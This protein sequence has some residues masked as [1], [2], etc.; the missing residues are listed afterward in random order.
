MIK[1]FS[2][3]LLAIIKVS[4]RSVIMVTINNSNNNNV[5]ETSLNDIAGSSKDVQKQSGVSPRRGNKEPT[6][7]KNEVIEYIVHNFGLFQE[8]LPSLDKDSQD[9]IK[10]KVYADFKEILAKLSEPSTLKLVMKMASLQK[11]SK[12]HEDLTEN[13]RKIFEKLAS[14][15]EGLQDDLD[16]LDKVDPK[17]FL[18]D[19]EVIYNGKQDFQVLNEFNQNSFQELKDL[20]KNSQSEAEQEIVETLNFMLE[21]SH[22]E[23]DFLEEALKDSLKSKH[24]GFQKDKNTGLN[25]PPRLL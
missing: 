8:K 25:E 7:L 18:V 23:I 16:K 19:E 1:L 2:Y 4:L 10:A 14:S 17:T 6:T 9:A 22:L 24:E 11:E 21:S 5:N 20:T 13:L 12:K 3:N 15:D